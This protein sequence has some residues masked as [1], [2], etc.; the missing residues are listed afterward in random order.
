MIA[1]A[2]NFACDVTIINF[3]SKLLDIIACVGINVGSEQHL[4]FLKTVC[5]N[6]SNRDFL[7][8]HSEYVLYST[9]LTKH[10]SGFW[11]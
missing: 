6:S 8:F 7:E 5:L 9:C 10:R 2:F 4:P 11:F 1:H 3:I